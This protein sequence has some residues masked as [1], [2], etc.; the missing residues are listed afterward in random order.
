[1]KVYR[2]I[3]LIWKKLLNNVFD[4]D[5]TICTDTNG[6]YN[7]A[8][9]I[10]DHVNTINRLHREGHQITLFTARGIGSSLNNGKKPVRN[11]KIWLKTSCANGE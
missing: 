1:M 6:D 3:D 10:M 2:N 4:I 11:G 9:S 5:G 8:K 7:S